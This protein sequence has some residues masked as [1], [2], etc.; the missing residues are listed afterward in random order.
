MP[1]NVGTAALRRREKKL[2]RY[3]ARGLGLAI[4]KK[5][6]FG[7]G[8]EQKM[9]S[10]E[11]ATPAG[12][13]TADM[14]SGRQTGFIAMEFIQLDD[15]SINVIA[16]VVGMLGGYFINKKLQQMVKDKEAKVPVRSSS[17]K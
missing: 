10:R 2:R 17:K 9:A 3:Q 15:S 6:D 13:W 4:G 11:V 1:C 5:R 14:V 7:R 12:L 16:M 8:I